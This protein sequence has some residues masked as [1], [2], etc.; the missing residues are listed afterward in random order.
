VVGWHA[1]PFEPRDGFGHPLGPKKNFE[2]L[3]DLALGVAESPPLPQEVVRPPPIS[4]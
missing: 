2:F 4:P 1:T 3:L